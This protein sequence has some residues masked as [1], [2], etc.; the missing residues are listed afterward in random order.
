MP[1]ASDLDAA[2]VPLVASAS[3]SGAPALPI[4]ELTLADFDFTLP[5]ARIALRPTHPRDAAR[6]LVVRPKAGITR[7]FADRI[8]R[9]LPNLL[10]PGDVL[11]FNDT[12]VIPA[13]LRGVRLRGGSRSRVSATLHQRLAGNCWTAFTRPAKRIAMGDTILFQDA[14]G[15]ASVTARVAAR[16]E[17]G[18]ETH[19]IDIE[20]DALDAAND[21]LGHVE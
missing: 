14:D 2:T 13:Q 7:R 1:A 17:D 3:A 18:A 19:V 21:T 8:V 11:V 10:D 6:L 16:E 5:E 4:D 20:G 15:A 9:D 12:K